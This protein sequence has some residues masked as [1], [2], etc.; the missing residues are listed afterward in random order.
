MGVGRWTCWHLC[1]RQAF[2]VM[3]T[4]PIEDLR[5][6]ESTMCSSKPLNKGRDVDAK[7]DIDRIKILY[8][9]TTVQDLA[10]GKSE[11]AM[12]CHQ[13]ILRRCLRLFRV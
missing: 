13:P 7:G 3:S 6:V 9:M 11:R 8:F 12:P 10:T 4:Q 2:L 1:F 5:F